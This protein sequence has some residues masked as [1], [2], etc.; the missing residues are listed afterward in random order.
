MLIGTR[1][2]R[3][4]RLALLVAPLVVGHLA[5]AGGRRLLAPLVVGHLAGIGYN[6]SERGEH[7]ECDEVLHGRTSRELEVEALSNGSDS[8]LTQ[9]CGRCIIV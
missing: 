5:G 3:R 7:D 6:N 2:C 1:L 4:G 8:D 9:G